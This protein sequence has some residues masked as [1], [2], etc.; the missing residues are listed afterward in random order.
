[1]LCL[2]SFQL[3]KNTALA[4]AP[5]DYILRTLLLLPHTLTFTFWYKDHDNLDEEPLKPY[6]SCIVYI[7]SKKNPQNPS[8]EEDIEKG[9]T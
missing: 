6:Y 1:M 4:S 9:E 8:A 5:I 7:L 3:H 2:R